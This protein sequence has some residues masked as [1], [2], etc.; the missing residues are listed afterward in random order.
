MN[1]RSLKGQPV[2]LVKVAGHA[3]I[4]GN[5]AADALANLGA[6]M[7]PLKE[8]D[9][10]QLKHKLDEELNTGSETIQPAPLRIE[11][12]PEPSK[13]EPSCAKTLITDEVCDMHSCCVSC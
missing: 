12:D 2:Q 10:E 4:E 7:P 11:T 5:E 1:A 9:W 6:T 8:R 13:G 3:G